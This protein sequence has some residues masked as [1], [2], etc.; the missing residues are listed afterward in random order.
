MFQPPI[1]GSSGEPYCGNLVLPDAPDIQTDYTDEVLHMPEVSNFNLEFNYN[2]YW[3]NNTLSGSPFLRLRRFKPVEG[4]LI[5]FPNYVLHGVDVNKSDDL[6]ISLTTDIRK[7]VD[8]NAP[9]TVILKSWAGRM[10]K[11]KEWK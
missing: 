7:V 6:R 3:E 1:L 10:A 11:I 4:R 2:A 9:N 8:K 5:F